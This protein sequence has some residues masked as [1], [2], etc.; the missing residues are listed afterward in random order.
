MGHFKQNKVQQSRSKQ[1][2]LKNSKFIGFDTSSE[3]TSAN[4]KE[5]LKKSLRKKYDN[6]AKFHHG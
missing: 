3:I 1:K 6:G 2:L 4:Y 5:A